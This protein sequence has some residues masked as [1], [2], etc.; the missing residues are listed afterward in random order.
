MATQDL[1]QME[2]IPD[3]PAFSFKPASPW[4]EK[5]SAEGTLIE[6]HYYLHPKLGNCYRHKYKL[7]EDV[8]WIDV[9]LA[10]TSMQVWKLD[11]S[12]WF[13]GAYATAAAAGDDEDEE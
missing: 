9:D 7:G 1:T 10:G 12:S 3:K 5:I 8:W 4:P 13:E 6:A 2:N 11:G